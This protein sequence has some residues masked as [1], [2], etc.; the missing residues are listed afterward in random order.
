MENK[1]QNVF[2]KLDKQGEQV[3]DISKKLEGVSVN[4]LYA[5][6]KRTW[7]YGD[8]QTAQKY[9]N[10]ISLLRPLDWEAPLYASL[11]NF[12]GYHNLDF[13]KNVN[14]QLEKIYISTIKY[15]YSLDLE[16]TKKNEEIAKCLEI[17]KK[18]IIS[19][20]NMYFDY[21]DQLDDECSNYI[22]TLQ[23]SILSIYLTLK[24]IKINQSHEF[25]IDFSNILLDLISK[26]N[27]VSSKITKENLNELIGNNEENIKIDYEAICKMCNSNNL[28]NSLSNEEI[29]EIKLK[30][31]MY[32]EYDDKVIS[33]RIFLKNLIFGIVLIAFSIIGI[34]CCII[35]NLVYCLA[36]IFP[37]LYGFVLTLRAFLFK[38]KIKCSS[39]LSVKRIKN[40]L[41]S[42]GTIVTEDKFNPINIILNIIMYLQLFISTIF[43]IALIIQYT[44]HNSGG[45]INI[46]I[47]VILI[48]SALLYFISTLKN[49]NSYISTIDGKFLYK[50][51]EKIYQF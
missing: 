27:K 46:I 41:S 18:E 22:Y 19:L 10:H 31:T 3:E 21:K 26:T 23:N 34:V 44:E 36:F 16:E 33:K 39:Y 45:I 24:D 2:E 47:A 4:D 17:I 50:Y 1:P 20:K 8:F 29:K 30:G 42:N 13:W 9:Y 48:V 6:A 43:C 7:D 37:L 49:N 51:K 14:E 15:I 5:L 35:S 38:D 40:R 25:S 11:C 32:F 28:I 12:R